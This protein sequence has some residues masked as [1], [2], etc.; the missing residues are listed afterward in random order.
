M[1]E[2]SRRQIG[3]SV[4]EQQLM[5][6]EL[7][8]ASLEELTRAA[9]PPELLDHT[10]LRLP[11][12]ADEA[13]VLARLSQLAAQNNPGRSMIGLGY[14]GTITPAVIRRD[15]LTNPTWLTAYTPYQPEISQGR[16]QAL[17]VFQ[18]MVAELTGMPL[19]GAGLLDEATAVAEAA[20]MALRASKRTRVVVADGVF[21]ATWAVLRTRLPRVGATVE[22]MGDDLS[23]V[24][25]VIVQTPISDGRLQ[26]ADELRGLAGKAHAAGALVIASADLLA[27]TLVEPPGSW[28]ADIVVGTAQRFGMPLFYGGPHS[29]YLACTQALLRQMPG[30]L[31]GVSVDADGAP[32]LRLAMQTREQHIR[33]EKATSNICT[34]QALMGVAAALYG[35][36]HGP[37]GLTEIAAALAHSAQALAGDLVA[38]GYKLRHDHFFDTLCVET[39]AATDAIWQAAHDRGIQLRRGDGFIGVSI[40]EDATPVDLAAVRTAFGIAEVGESSWGGLVATRE[41]GFMAQPV[42]NEHHSETEF[43]RYVHGLTL[44][45]YALDTGMIPLGSCTMKLTPAAAAEAML[46]PGFANLHPGVPA[47][48]AT[49]YATLMREL[50]GWLT[51][52]TGFSALSF[53]PNAGSQG[54]LAGLLAIRAYHEARGEA[55]RDICLIPASAHGTN[56]ASAAMAGFN[57]QQVRVAADGCIDLD[58]LATKVAASGDRLAVVLVTY[59]S[60]HGVFEH[61]MTRVA[62]LAHS[63]GAQVYV[64]GANL[65]AL[66]GLAKP[67]RFGADVSHLN[68]HKTFAMPH[69]GGGPGVGPVAALDHLA[70]YLPSP[71]QHQVAGAAY[72]SAGLLPI[73]YAYLS[74]MGASG[75]RQASAVA[76]LNANYLAHRLRGAFPVLYSGAG[77]L[78]AHECIFD[79]RDLPHHVTVD[80][81]AKRLID[82]GFHAPTMSFPVAGTLMCEPTESESKGELDRF[83]DAMLSIRA[84]ID[85]IESDDNV[86]VNAPHTIA[87]VAADTWTHPYT[88]AQAGFPMGVTADKYWPP[89]A[90]I[91]NVYGD[92]NLVTSF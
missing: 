77:G 86:L 50:A 11:A 15:I 69:G 17:L 63:V 14:Y 90:R 84:E 61:T 59:P 32:G 42:F 58:D 62:E 68:L 73:S 7:G 18:T 92:R 54:E 41:A 76:V 9:L 83:V 53:Q 4:Q 29:A 46:L 55:G 38:G 33:R 31:V 67:G 22:Q 57:L 71:D 39:G 78:V 87:R 48:D 52:I 10:P 37:A 56:A 12:A 8:Y 21:D 19:A 88:R 89:V 5:L 34:A 30:R 23:D 72:G 40:G 2:F 1:T 44:K 80:D 24:A 36:Y 45:D 13:S 3:P 35:V 79:L 74:L 64:D 91:D 82:Y 60:T 49:G 28:G 81:V 65:N 25:A 43:M 6:T 47:E 51:E 26:S 66:A 16:L 27:L 20:A 85:A 75:I 70:P